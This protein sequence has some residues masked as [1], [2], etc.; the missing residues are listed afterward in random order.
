MTAIA[1]IRHGPTEW[2]ENGIVQGRSDIPLS[3]RGRKQVASFEIPAK[4]QNF[5]W[6]AS[7]LRRAAETAHIL[8]GHMVPTD[9]RLVEMD[10]SSWEG[11]TLSALRA[12][13]GDL[14]AAW[15]AEGLDF[16]APG[17]ESPRDVQ[18]RLKPFLLDRARLARDT[19]VVCH[20]GVI[21]AVYAL[22]IGWDMKSK[23]PIKMQDG[24]AQLFSL[25]EKGMPETLE[26]DVR[27][28]APSA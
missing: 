9:D 10:W 18:E 14:T 24:C 28:A 13:L 8:S 23:P 17:G 12:E 25:D 11:Q 2:N 16:R 6:V 7:P 27:L 4:L 22:A 21:R 15:E 3:M 26:F 1:M 20:K 19:I 5:D